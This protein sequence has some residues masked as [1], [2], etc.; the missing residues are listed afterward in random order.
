MEY[1]VLK[2]HVFRDERGRPVP[3][4]SGMLVQLYNRRV[5]RKLVEQGIVKLNTT[6]PRGSALRRAL[7]PAPS[8]ARVT[9]VGVFFHTSRF[10]SGGRVHLFQVGWTMAQM[11]ADVYLV[12]DGVPRWMRDYPADKRLHLVRNEANVPGDLDVLFTDGKDKQGA[13]A[14]GYKRRHPHVPLVV[15]NFETPNWVQEFAPNVARRMHIPMDCAKTADLVLANSG[16]SLRY[17]LKYC[18]ELEGKRAGVLPPAANDFAISAANDAEDPIPERYRDRPYVAWSARSSAYKGGDVVVRAVE[19]YPG[20]LNLVLVGAP[21]R[22]PANTDDHAFVKF[23]APITD[24]Q[25]MLVFKGA[26]AVAAP[27][28]FEGYGMVPAEALCCVTPCVA[29]DLPV[30]RQNYGERITYAKWNDPADFARKLHAGVDARTGRAAAPVP[31]VRVDDAKREY[32]MKAMRGRVERLPYLWSADT[33]ARKVSAHMIL[34]YGPTVQEAL[35]AV[36]PHV[37]EIVVAYGP[38]T[39]WRHVPPDGS[40][41]LVQSFPDPERKIKIITREEWENKREMRRACQ[42][43]STGTHVLVVDADEIYDNLGAWIAKAPDYGCPRWVHFWHDIEHYVHDTPGM[44]RWGQPHP[45]GGSVHTHTRWMRWRG[46]Y[47]WTSPR[48]TVAED[49]RG[50]KL[51]TGAHTREAVEACPEC[52]IYHLGHVLPPDLMRAKHKFYRTR[53]G[54]DPGRRKREEAWH[55]WNGEEGDCGDGIVKRV[56]WDV[57]E[58]VRKAWEKVK[59]L[60]D[61]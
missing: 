25:K 50:A 40:L 49:M 32:G 28:L 24:A 42:A 12:T 4:L 22:V 17:L 51:A 29:Y 60:R 58:L 53:D 8:Y 14:L 2:T 10:Y 30:L 44:A 31:E 1:V 37:H 13:M 57:P 3:K 36:Y 35:V 27:S 59:E 46:S 5:A 20:P 45:L 52:C 9:R 56:A 43:A 21:S 55:N 34:Y 47:R 11:G 23:D 6:P 26:A 54:D 18:P 48:G 7:D 61:G 19:S 15:L 16:E 33:G 41:E 38:T 39:L